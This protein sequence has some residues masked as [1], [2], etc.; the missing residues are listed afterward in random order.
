MQLN[1]LS[2]RHLRN[3]LSV[4]LTFNPHFNLF[5]GENGD[6]KTSLLEAIHLLTTGRSFRVHPCK[7][8]ITFGEKFCRVSGVVSSRGEEYP[9]ELIR[10]G[11]ERH[12]EGSIKIRLAEKDCHSISALAKTLPV[13]LINS[14]SYAILEAA[15]QFRR[16]FLDWVTFHVEHSFYP[17]WQRF[18][19]ALLQRNAVLRETTR[20]SSVDIRAW[21][22]EFIE[23]G[24]AIHEKRQAVL[25]ELIP[26]FSEI[27][28]SFLPLNKPVSIAYHFGWPMGLSLSKALERSLE[29]DRLWKYTT[30]GPQRADLE[31]LVGNNPVK[32]VL[33]RGQSKLFI[34][35]LLMARA[36]LLYRRQ[37]RRCVFLIDDLNAELDKGSSQA[38]IEGLNHLGG[39]VLITSI[40]GMPLI[41]LLKGKEH[42]QFHVKN[43]QITPQHP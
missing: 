43:G 42:H 18:K 41:E 15:P 32:N 39:Q 20:V 31:V 23:A 27:V 5:G 3:L 35:G 38:L 2:I 6:G 22:T 19:R 26:I 37:G 33:S 11:V 28:A 29:K 4:D 1:S 7:Q 8:V 16:Q 21:D 25:E 30:V 40:E 10:L 34:C 36:L 14:H 9:K 13:Q 24:E 17:T 12:Q